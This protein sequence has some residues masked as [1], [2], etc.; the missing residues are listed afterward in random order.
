MMF[1]GPFIAALASEDATLA[2]RRPLQRTLALCGLLCVSACDSVLG[3]SEFSVHGTPDAGSATQ[4]CTSNRDC[5]GAA[6]HCVTALRRCAALDS[7]DCRIVTGPTQAEDA[8]LIGSL[9]SIDGAPANLARQ[10]SAVLAVE[11][12]NA[13]GGVPSGP[14]TARPLLMVSCDAKPDVMRAATHLIA[15]LR[16]QAIIGPDSTQD[17]LSLATKLAIPNGALML[18][19]TLGPANAADLVDDDLIWS[20]V[21]NDLQRAALMIDQVHGLETALKAQRA[22]AA[23]K[24]GIL[25]PRGPVGA[26]AVAALSALTFGDEPLSHPRNLGDHVRIDSYPVTGNAPNALVPGYAAFAPDVV[27]LL[28]AQEAIAQWIAPLEQ[29]WSS[30]ER[31]AYLLTDAA[32]GPELLE[33]LKARGDLA[34]RVRGIG[35]TAANVSL[36]AQAAFMRAYRARFGDPSALPADLSACYDAVYAIALGAASQGSAA[37]SGVGIAAGLRRLMGGE[38]SIELGS[39]TFVAGAASLRTGKNLSVVGTLTPLLWDERGALSAGTLDSWCIENAP[40]SASFGSGGRQLD[41]ASQ[42]LSGVFA[43]CDHTTAA[44]TALRSDVPGAPNATA[45]GGA[46]SDA[47]A[48]AGAGDA[49]SN[50]AGSKPSAEPDAGRQL[51]TDAGG[52]TSTKPIACGALTCDVSRSESCCVSMLR[53]P[54]DSPQPGDFSCATGNAACAASFH[55][56]SDAHCGTGQVCCGVGSAAKCLATSACSA[57]GGTH[58]GCASARDCV[59]T[60]CCGR[61]MPA[62][63]NFESI[64]CSADCP[65][66]GSGYQLCMIDADCVTPLGTGVCRASPVLPALK[67]CQAF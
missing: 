45:D 29:A 62:S 42:E 27:V 43:P 41:V 3:L 64:E 19:P 52:K 33:L 55:C 26:S 11:E 54:P 57:M 59:G 63:A 67:V 39:R 4:A 34:A 32:Q 61:R 60:V 36:G 9:L 1:S 16:A 28:G 40:G 8:I 20:M 58:L 7:A 50:D 30:G 6:D 46:A 17:P 24:L 66:L 49:G 35:V 14:D 18:S 37:I 10:Q 44:D 13:A 5:R 12:I 47:T 56:T 38:A 21:P 31:P 22:K 48:N 15:E 25:A 2:M 23:L 53:A 51:M 65:S